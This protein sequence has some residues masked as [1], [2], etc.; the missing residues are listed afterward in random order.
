[1]PGEILPALAGADP[2]RG[3]DPEAAASF[4]CEVPH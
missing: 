1:V 2:Y 3:G 4:A